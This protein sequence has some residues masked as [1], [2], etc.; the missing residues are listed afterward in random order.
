MNR[1]GNRS[2][3]DQA[4]QVGTPECAVFSAGVA[5]VLGLL[6]LWIGFWKTLFIFCLMLIGAFIGGVEDKQEW[7]RGLINRIFPAKPAVAFYREPRHGA[8]KAQRR[9][10]P[11]ADEDAAYEEA[12][13]YEDQEQE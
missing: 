1:N 9:P 4:F 2:F 8:G 6:F 10:A 13:P 3:L 11:D 7:I 5:M 12:Y